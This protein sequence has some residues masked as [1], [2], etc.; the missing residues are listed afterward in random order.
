[1][2]GNF[3]LGSMGGWKVSLVK[4]FRRR[5][6]SHK[7]ILE[8]MTTVALHQVVREETR[9]S[10]REQPTPPKASGITLLR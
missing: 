10:L 9:Q 5:V 7:V 6:S 2:Y 4:G 3:S 1:M 8:V